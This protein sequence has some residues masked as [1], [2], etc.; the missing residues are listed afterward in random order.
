MMK[1]RTFDV[2]DIISDLLKFKKLILFLT[3]F[4]FVMSIIIMWGTPKMYSSHTSFILQVSEGKK[5]N[6]NISSVAKLVGI[7]V[8][9]GSNENL[10]YPT[11]YPI[12]FKSGP[13]QKKLLNSEITSSYESSPI[14]ISDYLGKYPQTSS[15]DVILGYTIGL[16]GKIANAIKP[17]KSSEVSDQLIKTSDSTLVYLSSK[18]EERIDFLY[19]NLSLGVNEDDGI[20]EI[21]SSFPEALA[22]AQIAGIIQNHLQSYIIESNIK[23]TRI[24]F[25][26]ITDRLEEVK[27]DYEIKRAIL[28]NYQDRNIN[29]RSNI[30]LNR[31]TQL[32]NDFEL[33]S[34]VYSNVLS[35][36]ESMKLQL[37][38]DTPVFMTIEPPAVPLNASSPKKLRG[39]IL[40]TIFGSI[41][42]IALVYLRII[43]LDYARVFL[44]K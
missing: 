14:T 5:L 37:K 12:I 16:P 24:E 17:N 6:S 2:E 32:E 39:V 26:Y 23:K 15:L 27:D 3:I 43:I 28:A 33:A 40:I 36:H 44:N 1:E 18:E 7:N 29:L 8:G 25:Q 31:L 35:E 9:G 38:R 22:S 13:F 42:V 10:I 4:I 19:E 30:A 11:L 20:I 34:E 41:L 21:N